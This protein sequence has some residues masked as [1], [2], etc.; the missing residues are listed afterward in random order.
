VTPNEHFPIPCA[1]KTRQAVS[2]YRDRGGTATFPAGSRGVVTKRTSSMGQPWFYYTLNDGERDYEAV[3]HWTALERVTPDFEINDTVELVADYETEVLSPRRQVTI[4]AGERFVSRN[5]ADFYDTVL[6]EGTLVDGTP[7][8]KYVPA[9][10]LGKVDSPADESTTSR[11]VEPPV[12]TV[13][14]LR[15]AAGDKVI[16]AR[17]IQAQLH[18]DH[19]HRCIAGGVELQVLLPSA[20]FDGY[21]L[22]GTGWGSDVPYEVVLGEGDLLDGRPVHPEAPQTPQE[23]HRPSPR[24]R[25]NQGVWTVAPVIDM[26]GD[27]WPAD[28]LV[29][30][31]SITVPRDG[32]PILYGCL[33]NRDRRDACMNESQLT[34]RPPNAK[35]SEGIPNDPEQPNSPRY[36]M[37]SR[38]FLRQCT[39]GSC[40]EKH[41][42]GSEFQ[43][44]SLLVGREG[45]VTYGLESYARNTGIPNLPESAISDRWTSDDQVAYEAACPPTPPERLTDVLELSSDDVRRLLLVHENGSIWGDQEDEEDSVLVGHLFDA[46]MTRLVA[47]S[48]PDD[49][50]PDTFDEQTKWWLD[51]LPQD[52]AFATATATRREEFEVWI[53]ALHTRVVAVN[54][55]D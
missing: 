34:E 7:F 15:F 32:S 49:G 44:T 55:E 22:R 11:P 41:V 27:S 10:K 54:K 35:F 21:V 31:K 20:S 47:E 25:M 9:T 30:I 19:G 4:L 53:R 18:G 2:G 1:V 6:C 26:A 3:A 52:K 16:V 51:H 12:S 42:A 37:N 24:Y 23:E 45:V 13:S 48:T 14:K 33:H 39:R 36:P 8:H 46:V 40:G 43:V 17:D 28:T 5:Y 38:V 50:Y 29:Q